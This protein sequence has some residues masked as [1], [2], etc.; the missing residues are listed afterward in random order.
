ML[1]GDGS[2]Y[3]IDSFDLRTGEDDLA[4]STN[5]LPDII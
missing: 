4:V 5:L 1:R 2:L 3:V